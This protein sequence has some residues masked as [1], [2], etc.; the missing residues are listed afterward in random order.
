MKIRRDTAFGFIR[1]L[2]MPNLGFTGLVNRR[3]AALQGLEI[4]FYQNGNK[5]GSRKLI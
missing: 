3:D 2:F 4:S 1:V 5:M